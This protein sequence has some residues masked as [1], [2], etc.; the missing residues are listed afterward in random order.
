MLFMHKPNKN[1][2]KYAF[3]WKNGISKIF[4]EVSEQ[5][6]V[7]LLQRRTHLKNQIASIIN[8]ICLGNFY[9]LVALLIAPSEVYNGGHSIF[10]RLSQ[11]MYSF[12]DSN[13]GSY[14]FKINAGLYDE[15]RFV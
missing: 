2:T 6:R 12:I 15:L 11:Q 5:R 7:S 13:Y 4:L 10:L 14:E 9:Y 8:G 3:K 1:H